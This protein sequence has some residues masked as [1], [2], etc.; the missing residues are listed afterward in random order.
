MKL[1]VKLNSKTSNIRNRCNRPAEACYLRNATKYD[2]A[3]Y[4]AFCKILI[5]RNLEKRLSLF[6][7]TRLIRIANLIKETDGLGNTTEV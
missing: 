4:S 7:Q 5:N 1:K 3:F 2:G 6:G